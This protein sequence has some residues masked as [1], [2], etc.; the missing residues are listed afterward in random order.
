MVGLEGSQSSIMGSFGKSN[1][2]NKYC[3]QIDQLK[4]ALGEKGLELVNRRLII[5][6]QDNARLNVSLM[7]RQKLLQLGWEVL[8]LPAYLPDTAPSN[9]RLFW[10]LPNYLNGKKANFFPKTLSL[11]DFKRHLEQ[12]FPQKDKLFWEDGIMKLPDRWQ[13][14]VEQNG[15]HVVQ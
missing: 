3:S 9:F 6:H 15:E 2:S 4:A 5:F 1:N 11:E 7:T 10:S 13:K 8:I 12:F 14:V